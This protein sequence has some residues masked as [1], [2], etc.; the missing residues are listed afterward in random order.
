MPAGAR[1]IIAGVSGSPRS[2]PALRRAAG[3]AG[4]CDA[5]LLPLHV[6]APPA[7]EVASHQFPSER[8]YQ[9]WEDG[10]WQRLWAALD[11]AFGGLPRSLRVQPVIAQGTPG[12]T[13]VRAA[14]QADDVL[15]VGMG[16]RGRASRLWHG[17]VSRYCLA[18]ATCPV[19]AIPA[20][21][22][23]PALRPGLAGRVAAWVTIAAP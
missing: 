21:E 19:V 7:L 20:P 2:L 13:L 9:E 5:T 6:W 10:A 12:W 4:A 11:T 16:R 14:S 15:V 8:L 3:L 22:L 1:R 17:Q 23:E 18:H